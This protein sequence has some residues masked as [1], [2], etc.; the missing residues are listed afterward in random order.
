LTDLV[1]HIAPFNV[2]IRSPF[3]A[4]AKHI[5][6][7]YANTRRCGPKEFVDFDVKVVPGKGVRRWWRQQARFLLDD[8]E[9]FYPL[10]AA[11]AAPLLEWGLNWC[12]ASRP[13][14]LL[15]MHAAVLAQ[16][17]NALMMPGFPGAGK[18]TLCATLCLQEHWQLLSDE[19][20]ILDPSNVQVLPH[21]RP[22]SLKNAS[23][24]IAQSFP[25]TRMGP[26]YRNTRKGNISHAA[27][28]KDAMAM[29]D[30]SAVVKWVV[31]PQFQSEADAFCEEM[32]RA[33]AFALISEQSFNQVRMGEAGFNALCE[34]LSGARCFQISYGS[35]ADGL[36]LIRGITNT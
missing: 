10:P 33:E 16:S 6:F 24:E 13:L 21:P 27:S 9:S 20:T 15:V 8:V 7:F 25:S 23:I 26:V 30:Q 31:F 2:R 36:R 22:I 18:S 17:R 1:L 11:Q 34:M 35:T 14:G 29:A 28:P 4:V 32:S 12:V 5:E 19:L 3:R